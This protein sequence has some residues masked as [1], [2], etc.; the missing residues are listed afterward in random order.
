MLRQV[1]DCFGDVVSFITNSASDISP[2]NKSKLFDLLS[3]PS[4]AGQ[5]QMELAMAIDVCE[6]FV[7]AT[8]TL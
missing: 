6:P 5:L 8:Y 2:A 4:K 1:H 7:K 3:N